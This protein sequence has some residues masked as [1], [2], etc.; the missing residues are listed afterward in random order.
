MDRHVIMIRMFGHVPKDVN[1]LVDSIDSSWS[2][3][4]RG[5]TPAPARQLLRVGQGA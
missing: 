1:R 5:G 3:P 2:S 4:P